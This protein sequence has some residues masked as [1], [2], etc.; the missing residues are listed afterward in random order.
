M[1][2]A[3]FDVD[4]LATALV[5]ALQGG[6]EALLTAYS[7]TSLERVWNYQDFALWMTDTMH[8]AGDPTQNGT[9]LQMT[10]RARLAQLQSSPTAARLHAEYQLGL[11]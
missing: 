2:L 6:D 8:N 10:A 9:F 4:T 7:D 3:L 5:A 1:N 11:N